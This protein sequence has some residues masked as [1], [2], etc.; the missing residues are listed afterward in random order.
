MHYTIR[1]LLPE[2][3]LLLDS[4][5]MAPHL[6]PYDPDRLSYAWSAADPRVDDLQARLA[7]LVETGLAE[8]APGG[9]LYLA[10]N[11]AVRQ[12]AGVGEPREL[13]PLG[14]TEGRPRLTE[15]WFC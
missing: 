3:S 11:R 9:A 5:D 2:G 8:G 4:P 15:P 13:V 14:S 6:G 1:L 10:V 12:A 7:E